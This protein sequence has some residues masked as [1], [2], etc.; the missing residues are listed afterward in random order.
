MGVERAG[1]PGRARLRAAHDEEDLRLP[2]RRLVVRSPRGSSE[3]R[4]C[5]CALVLRQL[6]PPPPALGRIR[7]LRV[8]LARLD[9]ARS[10]GPHRGRTGHPHLLVNL[11]QLVDP[12]DHRARPPGARAQLLNEL[13]LGDHRPHLRRE[14]IGITGLEQQPVLPIAD[15]L[16]HAAEVR[17]D[18]RDSGRLRRI[19]RERR[20]LVPGRGHDL[21]VD[22]GEALRHAL[23]WDPAREAD[24]GIA[25]GQR[26]QLV[27]VTGVPPG[28]AHDLERRRDLGPEPPERLQ[29]H[30]QALRRVDRPDVAEP[31]PVGRG[32]VLGTHRLERGEVDAVGRDPDPIGRH[33]VGDQHVAHQ[34]GWREDRVDSVDP[35]AQE[36]GPREDRSDHR[37]VTLAVPRGRQGALGDPPVE[38]GAALR[39]RRRLAD[40][41]PALDPAAFEAVGR[42]LVGPGR[43]L[44]ARLH[45][46]PPEAE[47]PEVGRGEDQRHAELAEGVDGEPG[48]PAD[49]EHVHD[50][51]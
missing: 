46:D 36:L 16:R 51:G 10:V 21:G 3:Q 48:E 37:G 15:D 27:E 45:Q 24:P 25:R 42:D 20:V 12:V 33:P 18:H 28:V 7:H 30:V 11:K 32:A 5:A 31:D 34:L 47:G 39:L 22:V 1:Q 44:A 40:P 41:R 26:A 38:R 13:R 2:G 43:E 29:H 35:L 4:P 49:M 17:G 19:D 23:V 14:G 9:F 6:R 50:V 8:L